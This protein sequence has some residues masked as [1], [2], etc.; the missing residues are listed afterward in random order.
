M[1]KRSLLLGVISGLLAGI[2]SIIYQKVYAHSL[3]ADF[4]TIATP[5][6]II[7]ASIFGGVLAAVGYW[8]LDKWLKI[9][10]EIVFNFIFI[11]YNKEIV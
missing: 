6:N 11:I 10:G 7:C 3:G 9:K 8:L 1:F 2:T 4:I 5:V